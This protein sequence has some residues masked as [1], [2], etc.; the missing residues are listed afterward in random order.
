MILKNT[1]NLWLAESYLIIETIIQRIFRYL[2]Q[3]QNVF[4]AKKKDTGT[5]N[6][7]FINTLIHMGLETSQSEQVEGPE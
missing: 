4:A 6:S 5:H 3:T 1:D 7:N 2:H